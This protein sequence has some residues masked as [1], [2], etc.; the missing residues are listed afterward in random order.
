MAVTKII[1]SDGTVEYSDKLPERYNS[2]ISNRN[3]F[4]EYRKLH[5]ANFLISPIW[6][7]FHDNL[8]LELFTKNGATQEWIEQKL[9]DFIDNYNG[10]F[11]YAIIG[12]VFYKKRDFVYLKCT[13][14][15]NNL[16]YIG[17]QCIIKKE[18][19]AVTIFLK[20]REYHLYYLTDIWEKENKKT[21]QRIE[22][23]IQNKV[24]KI[25]IFTEK[26]YK[27]VVN[28]HIIFKSDNTVSII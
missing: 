19:K 22:K 3:I 11:Y 25:E 13:I 28:C 23:C 21:F 14:I 5:K 18:M 8:E 24:D 26:V 10:S 16:F 2:I 1:N 7:Q 17:Y 12:E 15:I 4:I 6:V 27:S 20:N 9:Y